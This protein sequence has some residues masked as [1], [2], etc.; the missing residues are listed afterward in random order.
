MKRPL[1]VFLALLLSVGC[2]T[3]SSSLP[4]QFQDP[5]TGFVISL[6][7]SWRGFSVAPQKPERIPRVK[8]LVIRHPRW[9]ANEPYQD[10]L[11]FAPTIEQWA[12]GSG[13]ALAAG[14]IDEELY[15]NSRYVFAVN[16]RDYGNF[17]GSE[18]GEPGFVQN[19]REVDNILV[20]LRAQHPE[21]V[22]RRH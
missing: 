5:D 11:I 4:L 10:I 9:S 14:G 1:A 16:N 2:S 12:E 3:V 20:N 13:I 8:T 18:P 22:G 21:A 7:E 6:P 17:G 15:R 19:T